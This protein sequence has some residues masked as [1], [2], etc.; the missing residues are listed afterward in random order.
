MLQGR[1]AYAGT[2]VYLMESTCDGPIPDQV[3][4]E[5]G[6]DGYFEILADPGKVYRCL[7][8]YH[9]GYLFGEKGERKGETGENGWPDGRM[10]TIILVAGDVTQDNLIDISDLDAIKAQYHSTD[11]AADLDGDGW[12]DISDLSLASGNFNQRG[13]VST[14]R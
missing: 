4:V 14:W 11:Q 12:V 9:K 5:T 6:D 8:V 1:T 10:G 3:A 2:K 7:Q 13:P